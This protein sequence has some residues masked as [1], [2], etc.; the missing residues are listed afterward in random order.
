[1]EALVQTAFQ[2]EK[3][4]NAQVEAKAEIFTCSVVNTLTKESAL[5]LLCRMAACRQRTWSGHMSLMVGAH[6][7]ARSGGEY[8]GNSRLELVVKACSCVRCARAQH[9][10]ARCEAMNEDCPNDK[11]LHEVIRKDSIKNQVPR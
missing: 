7:A 11:Q 8:C 1:M 4:A 10:A 9:C 3:A 2:N 5:C 6:H